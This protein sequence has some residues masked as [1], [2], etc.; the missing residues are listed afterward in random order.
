MRPGAVSLAVKIFMAIN[1][2]LTVPLFLI[3]MS[4]AFERRLL[5]AD[6]F[7]TPAGERKRSAGRLVLALASAGMALLV[8]SFGILTGLTGAF[9]NNLLAFVSAPVLYFAY[10]R[11][12]GRWASVD[13]RR[14]AE[15]ALLAL[16]LAFGI[17]LAVM[18][19]ESTVVALL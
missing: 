9:G 8:P 1:Q 6:A 3:P 19:T 4:E 12:A 13:A 17:Y 7:G 11:A 2:T 16:L 10:H 15:L 18:G 5:A 14:G